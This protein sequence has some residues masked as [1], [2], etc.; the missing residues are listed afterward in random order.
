MYD[1]R[2]EEKACVMMLM[3]KQTSCDMMF[4]RQDVVV[5]NAI[6][7][8]RTLTTMMVLK[9]VRALLHGRSGDGRSCRRRRSSHIAVVAAS[10]RMR[11]VIFR[12]PEHMS[13]STLCFCTSQITLWCSRT[14]VWIRFAAANSARMYVSRTPHW[15]WALELRRNRGIAPAS[16][17][18]TF[19]YRNPLF[20]VM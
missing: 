3:C 7:R 6:A 19:K 15:V 20:Y 17:H 5:D 11:R 1:S 16:G 18:V 4:C 2:S 12:N 10:I 8:T 14:S 9:N 13:S